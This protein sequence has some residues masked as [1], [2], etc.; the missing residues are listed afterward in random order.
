MNKWVLLSLLCLAACSNSKNSGPERLANGEAIINGANVEVGS[1]IEKATV[2]LVMV[3]ADRT[4][5][6]CTGTLISKDLVVTAA[7]CVAPLQSGYQVQVSF[8]SETF[9]SKNEGELREIERAYTYDMVN[10]RTYVEF[11]PI[12]ELNDVAVIKLLTSAP[13]TAKP[14]AILGNP[15]WL[16][17]GQE[18]ILAGFGRTVENQNAMSKIMQTTRVKIAK[19]TGKLIEVDQTHGT[20]ACWG[21]SGGPAFIETDRGLLVVGATSGA[22]AGSQDCSHNVVYSS[23]PGFKE[24]LQKVIPVLGGEAP[25]YI[26]E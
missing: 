21:D 7:H 18:V 23:L 3:D 25:V 17:V 24:F 10:P 6:F 20:G 13:K 12:D 4:K 11:R 22:A 14:A 5:S 15:S 8:G 26:E 9:S 2:A 16:F 19:L 1:D